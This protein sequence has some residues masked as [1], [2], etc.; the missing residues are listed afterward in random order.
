[1]DVEV[2][3]VLGREKLAEVQAGI[4][5]RLDSPD[6][7]ITKREGWLDLSKRIDGMAAE[8]VAPL[9]KVGLERLDVARK[10]GLF[11][12]VQFDGKGRDVTDEKWRKSLKDKTPVEQAAI[13][14]Q[15][16]SLEAEYVTKVRQIKDWVES[17]PDANQD[18]FNKWY[19]ENIISASSIARAQAAATAAWS[20][21]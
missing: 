19:D 17:H 16:L 2:A 11:G 8:K 4:K 12:S 10:S 5:R 7:L 6:L 20:G 9:L 3:A 13:E 15:R 18:S 1:V 14:R 21:K